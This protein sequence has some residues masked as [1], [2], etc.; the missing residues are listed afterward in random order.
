[1]IFFQTVAYTSSDLIYQWTAGR[2]VN[3]ASDMKLSQFDLIATPTGNQTI[4]LNNGKKTPNKPSWR[5]FHLEYPGD[6]ST[7][8]VSFHLQR[9]MGDFVIQVS[10]FL[11]FLFLILVPYNIIIFCLCHMF[12]F[13]DYC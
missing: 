10:D 2:G 1:M 3:I 6:H 8:L 9:H 12:S 11:S 13:T 4:T 5:S 7:L